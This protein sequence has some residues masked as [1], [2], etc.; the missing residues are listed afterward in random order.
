[1]GVAL[2]E[3][4]CKGVTDRVV[5]RATA[6]LDTFFGPV[7]QCNHSGWFGRAACL[8][9]ILWE[10]GP[11]LAITSDRNAC[12]SE[13]APNAFSKLIDGGICTLGLPRRPTTLRGGPAT[14]SRGLSAPAFQRYGAQLN[15]ATERNVPLFPTVPVPP[16]QLQRFIRKVPL[17]GGSSTLLR[18]LLLRLGL[19]LDLVVEVLVPTL[20]ERLDVVEGGS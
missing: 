8:D 17:H 10:I 1:M 19:L 6:G 9:S 20:H 16:F 7:I 2:P 12:N 13:G 15:L 11:S 5:M 3:L 18:D 4:L 14:A